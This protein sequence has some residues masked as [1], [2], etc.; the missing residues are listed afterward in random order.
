MNYQDI[1]IQNF[2]I[3]CACQENVIQTFWQQSDVDLSGGMDFQPR[4]AV[5]VRFTHLNHEDFKYKIT[6]NNK[7]HNHEGMVRIFLAPKYDETG[8]TW[9]FKEQ[10]NMFIELDKFRVSRKYFFSD[11]IFWFEMYSLFNYLSIY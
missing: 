11:L 1:T 4:G 7:G 6:V 8:A 10:K 3:D 2:K 5:F 9:H